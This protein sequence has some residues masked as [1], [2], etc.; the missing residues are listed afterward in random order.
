MITVEQSNPQ[1]QQDGKNE[2][3]N[4]DEITD[5]VKNRLQRGLIDFSC[6]STGPDDQ[7]SR[8]Q[9]Q[10]SAKVVKISQEGFFGEFLF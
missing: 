8:K 7:A 9:N 10:G 4:K 3:S 1:T 6:H 2:D 5:L